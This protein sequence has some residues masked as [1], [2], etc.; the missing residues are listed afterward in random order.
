MTSGSRVAAD[1]RST[2]KKGKKSRSSPGSY[3]RIS[4]AAAFAMRCGR[5]ACTRPFQSSTNTLSEG[6]ILHAL[7]WSKH[8]VAVAGPPFRWVIQNQ[9][10][11]VRPSPNSGYRTS[12]IYF[13]SLPLMCV[14]PTL[15]E[16]ENLSTSIL[17]LRSPLPVHL[18]M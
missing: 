8:Q 1:T 4:V 9:T 17:S 16:L 7:V 12:M 6:F 10:F 15:R 13:H 3:L 11:P 5:V 2:A 18:E 14:T